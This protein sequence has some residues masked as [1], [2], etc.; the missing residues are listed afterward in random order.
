MVKTGGVQEV[1]AC[2]QKLSKVLLL[3][4]YAETG[5]LAKNALFESTNWV[6][7]TRLLSNSR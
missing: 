5:F 2:P 6:P 3:K 4:T 7:K 1:S